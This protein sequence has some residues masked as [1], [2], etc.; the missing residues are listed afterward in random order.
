MVEETCRLGSF[1][2]HHPG[3]GSR[4]M[5]VVVRRQVGFTVRKIC[6]TGRSMRMDM[7]SGNSMTSLLVSHVSKDMYEE[8]HMDA[9]R[10]M[11]KSHTKIIWLMDGS[12]PIGK[13]SG[14][15]SPAQQGDMDLDQVIGYCFQSECCNSG[16]SVVAIGQ[17]AHMLLGLTWNVENN[18]KL[19]WFPPPLNIAQGVLPS[20]TDQCLSPMYLEVVAEV[21]EEHKVGDDHASGLK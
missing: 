1:W 10:L 16:L 9:S 15:Q 2:R 14:K 19:T 13:P 21:I 6:A 17:A 20:R 4:V 3:E 12:C 11:L 18:G 8:D 5:V 7:K